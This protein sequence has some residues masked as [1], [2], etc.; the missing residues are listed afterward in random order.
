MPSRIQP[1]IQEYLSHSKSAYPQGR[2][3]VDIV[4][5]QKFLAARIKKFQE[6]IMITDIG[7]SLA[8]DNKVG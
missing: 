2:S 6:A 8:F 5:R 7:I 1:R 3:I 4:W